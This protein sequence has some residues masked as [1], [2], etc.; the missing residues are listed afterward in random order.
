MTMETTKIDVKQA[1]WLAWRR[2]Q[3]VA[4]IQLLNQIQYGHFVSAATIPFAL[5]HGSFNQGENI[6]RENFEIHLVAQKK[7]EEKR[8][9]KT[10]VARHATRSTTN[11][12]LSNEW[13]WIG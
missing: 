10:N 1:G 12:T 13:L 8:K 9:T 6:V 3:T 7:E 2:N 5:E 11:K 4:T